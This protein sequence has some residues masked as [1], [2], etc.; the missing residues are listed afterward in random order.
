MHRRLRLVEFSKEAEFLLNSVESGFKLV[1]VLAKFL[2]ERVVR[3]RLEL[4]R[5]PLQEGGKHHRAPNA[6]NN[7]YDEERPAVA[8]T[9]TAVPLWYRRTFF[10][11]SSEQLRHSGSRNGFP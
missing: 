10:T 3:A 4:G 9:G 5:E 6:R 8:V 7:E 2:D 1:G 11:A